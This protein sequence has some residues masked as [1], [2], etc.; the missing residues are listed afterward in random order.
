MAPRGVWAEGNGRLGCCMCPS[1][2]PGWAAWWTLC[3][4]HG[5]ASK[6]L[7]HALNRVGCLVPCTCWRCVPCT[8][9]GRAALAGGTHSPTWREGSSWFPVAEL[10]LSWWS[11]PWAELRWAELKRASWSVSLLLELNRAANGLPSFTRAKLKSLTT[12][13]ASSLSQLKW[14]QSLVSWKLSLKL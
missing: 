9:L 4:L 12:C 8:C 10:Q 1:C 14:K 2:A 13:S 11:W 6:G 3:G 7:L 5:S